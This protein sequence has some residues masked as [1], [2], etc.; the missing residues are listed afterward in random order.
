MHTCRKLRYQVGEW[1]ACSTNCT[2]GLTCSSGL[3]ISL[4][5]RNVSSCAADDVAC[6]LFVAPPVDTRVCGSESC[7]PCNAPNSSVHGSI[8]S[9]QGGIVDSGSGLKVC[10]VVAG[11]AHCQCR[12]GWS[13][14]RCHVEDS[15]GL[16]DVTGYAC[17]GVNVLH[18]PV[19]SSH[20]C[21]SIA[22]YPQ[23]QVVLTASL[24]DQPL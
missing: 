16:V 2:C 14:A 12:G 23:G 10:D 4:Q 15:E 24:L 11:R 13:G 8:C 9:E 1:S 17:P 6:A 20:G 5:T 21:F 18:C 22:F 3:R 19:H 7:M